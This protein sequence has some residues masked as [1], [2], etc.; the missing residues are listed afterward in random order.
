[1]IIR[2]NIY[3][4]AFL[5]LFIMSCSQLNQQTTRSLYLNDTIN[6]QG[7]SIQFLNNQNKEI[8]F[9]FHINNKFP[10][11]SKNHLDS[12]FK[13]VQEYKIDTPTAVWQYVINTTFHN[14]F[15]LSEKQWMHDPYIFS[16]SLSSGYCDDLSTLLINLWTE[17]GYKARLV[18]LEGHV[19]AEVYNKGKWQLFDPD[20]RAYFQNRNN[21]ISSLEEIETDSFSIFNP[22]TAFTHFYKKYYLTSQNNKNN[23]DWSLKD[24]SIDSSYILPANSAFNLY[25][26]RVQELNIANITLSKLSK[27]T[28]NIPLAPFCIQG[29]LQYKLKDSIYTLNK[30]NLKQFLD[31]YAE[32]EILS[33]ADYTIIYYLVNPYINIFEANNLIHIAATNKLIV[34]NKKPIDFT[35]NDYL[36]YW[37]VEKEFDELYENE[38]APYFETIKSKNLQIENLEA[39]FNLFSSFYKNQ[40]SYQDVLNYKQELISKLSIDEAKFNHILTAYYPQSTF[41]LFTTLIKD[42]KMYFI[43]KFKTVKYEN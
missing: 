6:L 14:T 10:L 7:N 12:I 31:T 13:L 33:A 19:A 25:Y 43:D 18:E 5:L 20:Q 23:T 9:Q 24:H 16:N 8:S 34:S 28:L 36:D 27:G 41:F 15:P 30:N 21:E 1:M 37:K 40:K 11:T 35:C 39:E 22:N 26:D 29:E 17:L 4:L 2:Y 3:F 32:I 38:L 42:E